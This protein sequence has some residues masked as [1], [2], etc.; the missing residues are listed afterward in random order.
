MRTLAF[1]KNVYETDIMEGNGEKA[2]A[3]GLS[4]DGEGRLYLPIRLDA[5]EGSGLNLI[6][7]DYFTQALTT[8]RGQ[9][10]DG[11]GIFHIVSSEQTDVGDLAAFANR[12]FRIDGFRAVASEDFVKTPRNGLESLFERCVDTYRPYMKEGRT[13]RDDKTRACLNSR[14]ITCPNLD[15]KRFSSCMRYAL[16]T[17]WGLKL[18]H[19]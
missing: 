6:P 10:S 14:R 17:D 2:R 12:F 7:V 15:Y 9:P 19:A 16:E 5:A 1:F 18:F 3:M 8:L 4:L 13:F 11:N